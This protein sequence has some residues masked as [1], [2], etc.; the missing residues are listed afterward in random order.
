M[1]DDRPPHS[2]RAVARCRSEVYH[3][4]DRLISESTETVSFPYLAYPPAS[5]LTR[6]RPPPCY[7]N[8]AYEKYK[9]E[10]VDTF[11]LKERSTLQHPRTY[12]ASPKFQ[13]SMTMM[14]IVERAVERSTFLCHRLFVGARVI[15][16][17]RTSTRRWICGPTR[18]ASTLY[19]PS[20]GYTGSC[21]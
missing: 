13:L 9:S 15:H 6:L 10:K 20:F 7:F 16:G 14:L 12:D 3:L 19:S 17:R 2:T 1:L 5:A 8:K 11:V 4:H 18:C 21:K